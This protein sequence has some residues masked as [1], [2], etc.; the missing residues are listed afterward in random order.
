[1]NFPVKAGPH[2]PNVLEP[3]VLI[4]T[5]LKRTKIFSRTGWLSVTNNDE[6]ILG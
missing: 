5:K 4:G 1:V 2:I 6:F 3:T